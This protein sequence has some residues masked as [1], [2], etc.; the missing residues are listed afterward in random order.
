MLIP[1]FTDQRQVAIYDSVN[2]Y[3]PGAQ[4]D[5]Y[6]GVA[7]EVRAETVVD[8]GC[9]TGIITLE[10]ARRGYRTIGVDHSPLMLKVAQQKP[11]ADVV[12]W[13]QGGAGV[14]GTPGADLAVMSG[15]VAQFIL[16]DS[17]W[18]ETLAGIRGALGPGR[19]LAF[20]SRD[21]RIREWER[22]AGRKR[23]I[24]VSPYG[25]IESWTEVRNVEGE[26]VRAVGHRRLLDSNEELVSPFA[27]RFR[28]DEL[29]RQSLTASGFSVESVFGDWDKRPSGPGEREL[30][31]IARS[32]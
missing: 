16:D 31:V 3:E 28:S 7:E 21:P 30:I 2:S 1:E 20:E 23:M 32:P 5:F 29:L 22:W 9:G 11:G 13:V 14:L 24:P 15:H 17:E 8:L 25:P 19:W 27:L 26:V 18:M 6:L 10:F 4:P 12:R